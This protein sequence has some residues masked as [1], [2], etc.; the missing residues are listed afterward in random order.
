MVSH[1]EI[2]SGLGRPLLGHAESRDQA[3]IGRGNIFRLQQDKDWKC[4]NVQ[5]YFMNDHFFAC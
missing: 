4:G 5:L 3:T 1:S 2:A